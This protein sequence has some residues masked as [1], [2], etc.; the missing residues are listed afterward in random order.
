[1]CSDVA[2]GE[3]EAS[4]SHES[5]AGTTSTTSASGDQQPTPGS[6]S[7]KPSDG[8]LGRLD[9][10][11]GLDW[12]LRFRAAGAGVCLV[13]FTLFMISEYYGIIGTVRTQEYTTDAVWYNL[14]KEGG[15]P[16]D[17]MEPALYH[18]VVTCQT[19]E[20]IMQRRWFVYMIKKQV[21]PC[22][23]TNAFVCD[24]TPLPTME[25]PIPMASLAPCHRTPPTDANDTSGDVASSSPI[26]TIKGGDLLL[27]TTAVAIQQQPYPTD[28]ELHGACLKYLSEKDDGVDSVR[29]FV[30]QFGLDLGSMDADWN[31]DLMYTMTEL[32]FGYGVHSLLAMG[33]TFS[34]VADP[35]RP[36]TV[37]MDISSTAS[38]LF[39][40]W[41]KVAEEKWKPYY[42]DCLKVYGLMVN[43]TDV[44]ELIADL[45]AQDK[46]NLWL[47]SIRQH[48]RTDYD[49]R[50]GVNTTQAVVSVAAAALSGQDRRMSS[51][52]VIAWHLLRSLMGH[53]EQC[54]GAFKTALNTGGATPALAT[55][56]EV[57]KHHLAF[58]KTIRGE[59][60][61]LIEGPSAMPIARILDITL[62]MARLQ[63]TAAAIVRG[64]VGLRLISA[65]GSEVASMTFPKSAEALSSKAPRFFAGV[66]TIPQGGF[67]ADWLRR[68]RAWQVLPPLFQAHLDILAETVNETKFARQLFEPPYYYDDGLVAYNYAVLGQASAAL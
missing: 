36:F 23:E 68:L 35:A 62:M 57:C 61:R 14:K 30:A 34:L 17:A 64:P 33:A 49:L 3:G 48:G 26:P 37:K 4:S 16:I 28:E 40:R 56:Q 47:A 58:T 22:W 51:R 9:Q 24:G 31:G 54:L 1:M 50:D 55:P 39:T 8:E 44:E 13:L 27:H 41:E 11:S 60:I 19:P 12:E 59:A 6:S 46:K 42:K 25:E 18:W 15:L 20:C 45:I 21:D 7:S 65:D 10:G 32:S 43:D 52:K 2:D 63:Q 5:A 38:E 66:D 53:K 29:Q 67:V